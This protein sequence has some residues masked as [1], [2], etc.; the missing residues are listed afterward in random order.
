MGGLHAK[1]MV[2]DPGTA[3]WD[4][5]ATVP[6]DQI[7][8]PPQMRTVVEGLAF[9]RPLPFV[10]RVVFIATPHRGSIL[11]S[12]G[13]GRLASLAVQEP[14]DIAAIRRQAVA[15]NP[16][17]LRPE[18]ADKVP[19]TI[20]LLRPS[21]PTLETLE[22]LRPSCWVAVHSIV[23]DVHPSLT[24]SRD[25]CVVPVESAH[26]PYALSEICVPA[27]HTRVHHHPLAVA[28][29]QR[30]LREHLAELGR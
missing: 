14:R 3:F 17:A 10:K 27:K 4:A 7:R 28:E 1:M 29:L 11:A 24:G 22:R 9:F 21:S 16:G 18:Y 20:D 13:I 30:I 12:L 6:F 5:I 19:T 8:L 25:D 26:T 23:G 2:V 15:M